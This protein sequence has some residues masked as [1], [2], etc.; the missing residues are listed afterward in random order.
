M[1]ET[2]LIESAC[3]NCT[4]LEAL[5]RSLDTARRARAYLTATLSLKSLQKVRQ[6]QGC[7]SCQSIINLFTGSEFRVWVQ[8]F[9]EQNPIPAKGNLQL[10]CQVMFHLPDGPHPVFQ[11]PP[12]EM[13]LELTVEHPENEIED[14]LD[15]RLLFQQRVWPE[16]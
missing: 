5:V 8:H 7:Q 15:V 13:L 9:N 2:K 10:K 12:V 14:N 6:T 11:G 16:E 4:A 1:T 3:S